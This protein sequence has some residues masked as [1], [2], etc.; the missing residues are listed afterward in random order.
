MQRTRPAAGDF[1]VLTLSLSPIRR[2]GPL[3]LALDGGAGTLMKLGPTY[4]WQFEGDILVRCPRCTARATSIKVPD[5]VGRAVGYRV[6]RPAPASGI[7]AVPAR[8]DDPVCIPHGTAFFG[9]RPGP[10]SS[11]PLAAARPWAFNRPHIDFLERFISAG[12]RERDCTAWGGCRNSSLESRL[13]HW[14]Q[15]TKSRE[16][17]LKTLG[18]LR[19]KLESAV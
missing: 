12:L 14:M 8:W 15:S 9:L 18:L 3:N 2:A 4:L 16:A 13:P 10:V 1:L 19:D 7:L 11:R 6:S 17:I 5:D